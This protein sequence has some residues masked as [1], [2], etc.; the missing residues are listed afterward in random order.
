MNNVLDTLKLHLREATQENN[1][2]L[3]KIRIAS[4]KRV[5]RA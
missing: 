2:A 5:Q 3:Q 4:R 1:I